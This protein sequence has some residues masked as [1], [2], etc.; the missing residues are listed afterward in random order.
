MTDSEVCNSTEPRV[1]DVSSAVE[2][3]GLKTAIAH[4]ELAKLVRRHGRFASSLKT[5]LEV[6]RVHHQ[7]RFYRS[8]TGLFR[9]MLGSK[10]DQVGLAT[11]TC[12][13][14]GVNLPQRYILDSDFGL[15]PEEVVEILIAVTGMLPL[16]GKSLVPWQGTWLEEVFPTFKDAVGYL[17]SMYSAIQADRFHEDLVIWTGVLKSR[18]GSALGCDGAGWRIV[19]DG[20]TGWPEQVRVLS[21]EVVAMAKGELF[22]C[23]WQDL[24]NPYRAEVE[25]RIDLG[26]PLPYAIID[27]EQWKAGG[28][29]T[30]L[31][32]KRGELLEE[33]SSGSAYIQDAI[34]KVDGIAAMRCSLGVMNVH[35][36]RDTMRLGPQIVLRS[37]WDPT[38]IDRSLFITKQNWKKYFGDNGEGIEKI[39]QAVVSG[40][41]S[42]EMARV[43]KLSEALGLDPKLNELLAVQAEGRL[44]KRLY[45][46]VVGMG[47]EALRG[48]LM[49][50]DHPLLPHNV[51]IAPR[52]LFRSGKLVHGQEVVFGRYPIV[53]PQSGASVYIVWD[54]SK[55]KEIAPG[56]VKA[57]PWLRYNEGI[58]GRKSGIMLDVAGDDDGDIGFIV[59]DPTFVKMMEETPHLLGADQLWDVFREKYPKAWTKLLREF[60]AHKQKVGLMPKERMFVEGYTTDK[61][62]AKA[63]ARQHLS[64]LA[65]DFTGPIGIFTKAQDA[66]LRLM[67]KP[68]LTAKHRTTLMLAAMAMA[69]MAQ[70]AVDSKK[71]TIPVYRWWKLLDS[72][73]WTIKVKEGVPALCPTEAFTGNV[74]KGICGEIV[75]AGEVDGFGTYVDISQE[76]RRY[77]R[78]RNPGNKLTEPGSI[79]DIE[80]NMRA[81][82]AFGWVAKICKQVGFPLKE[83][84]DTPGG[85]SHKVM[86]QLLP[87][88]QQKSMPIDHLRGRDSMLSEGELWHPIDH[89]FNYVVGT[90]IPG[91]NFPEFLLGEKGPECEDLVARF[92]KQGIKVGGESFSLEM[93][94]RDCSLFCKDH[95]VILP[96]TK[97]LML[98]PATKGKLPARN[99]LGDLVLKT[100]KFD[101]VIQAVKNKVKWMAQ[102]ESR[103]GIT[104]KTRDYAKLLDGAIEAA[105]LV[106]A[107]EIAKLRFG[108][109]MAL[110]RMVSSVYGTK[111]AWSMVCLGH[112]ALL[113]AVGVPKEPVCTFLANNWDEFERR[114]AVTAKHLDGDEF[115]AIALVAGGEELDEAGAPVERSETLAATH[116]GTVVMM[117]DKGEERIKTVMHR[118]S[119]CTSYARAQVTRKRG[120]LPEWAAENAKRILTDVN[121]RLKEPS[122]Q[123]AIAQRLDSLG[124]LD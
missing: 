75:D 109:L 45:R 76:G 94:K 7:F 84:R 116:P 6:Y 102:Q 27:R 46:Q 48:A 14:E 105:K 123:G 32:E 122:V 114:V 104:E 85:E 83:G 115:K 81:S 111:V 37:G 50:H 120:K 69:F 24:P 110:V 99:R 16:R 73:F 68:N 72:S 58:V 79:L 11:L 13:A 77:R 10:V 47:M 41:E 91:E 57:S 23:R 29:V 97:N 70:C 65:R 63:P 124:L 107:P 12:E 74:E 17:A 96:I 78:Y 35:H 61:T 28:K 67:A 89:V 119:H 43:Q 56:L 18:D 71:N 25:R 106:A 9:L 4:K 117:N 22:P 21:K 3:S 20:P 62:R 103:G 118:C 100:T 82:A 30:T 34:D 2:G 98:I 90:L 49:I 42:G 92:A 95:E 40:D 15:F 55:L 87:W 108:T 1:V 39:Y 33:Y 31:P 88:D 60:S 66:F 121:K 93:A 80:G 54:P 36:T 112:N 52:S 64:S 5:A 19:Y 101:A 44:R 8:S 53:S 38:N 113:E 26:L 86:A 51:I 59:T